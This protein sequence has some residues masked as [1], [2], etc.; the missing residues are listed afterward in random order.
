MC[1]AWMAQRLVDSGYVAENRETYEM[2]ERWSG[3]N[4]D[5]I[6][7]GPSACYLQQSGQGR[8]LVFILTHIADLEWGFIL[9]GDE[10][11]GFTSTEEEFVRS[12]TGFRT[13]GVRG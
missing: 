4:A 13:G 1:C 8:D 2:V 10:V 7:A 11:V 6:V 5:A 3:V 9:Q 12:G